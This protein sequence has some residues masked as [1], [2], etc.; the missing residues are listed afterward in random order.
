MKILSAII[1]AL[2]LYIGLLRRK[3]ASLSKKVGDIGKKD[4][5]SARERFR[6]LLKKYRDQ[7]RRKK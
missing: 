3:L 1:A 5:E 4:L 7:E 6:S 2:L